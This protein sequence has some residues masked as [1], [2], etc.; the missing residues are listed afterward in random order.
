MSQR[1]ASSIEITKTTPKITSQRGVF[2]W[3]LIFRKRLRE[4][5]DMSLRSS[6]PWQ[7]IETTTQ[8]RRYFDLTIFAVR[9]Q[10]N[11]QAL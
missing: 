3:T 8:H 1:I 6:A 11:D 2:C 5:R 9:A 4:P 10:Q 7:T